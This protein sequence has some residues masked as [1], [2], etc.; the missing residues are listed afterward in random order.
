VILMGR[1]RSSAGRWRCL[2]V[3]AARFIGAKSHANDQL[4][5]APVGSELTLMTAVIPA[6]SK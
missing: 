6:V 2:S 3:Q 5:V 1:G 4:G